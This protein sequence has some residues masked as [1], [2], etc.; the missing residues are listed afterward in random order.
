MKVKVLNIIDSKTCKVVSVSRKKHERYGKYVAV[1][2]K[3]V[4]DCTGKK[5][6]IGDEVEIASCKPLSKRKRWAVV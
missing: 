3:Y 5:L 6:T 4:V 1:Y 2:K